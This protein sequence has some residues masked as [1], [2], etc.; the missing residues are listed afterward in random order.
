MHTLAHPRE[1]SDVVSLQIG[2]KMLGISEATI[3]RHMRRPD[4]D[5]PRP[6]KIGRRWFFRPGDITGWIARKATEAQAGRWEYIPAH[7]QEIG[8]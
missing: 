3:H 2:C 4:C 7:G 8:A 1:A 6:F 5:T